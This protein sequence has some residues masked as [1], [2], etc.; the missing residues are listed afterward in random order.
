MGFDNLPTLDEALRAVGG[1][2]GKNITINALSISVQLM[3]LLALQ[4][5]PAPHIK[6]GVA[7]NW[8]DGVEVLRGIAAVSIML[9]HCISL[10]PWNVS[11]MPM[12]VFGA[13]WIDVDLFF[14]ISGYVIT[15]SAA[16][17][18]GLPDYARYFWRTR[19]ARILPLYYFTSV[20]FVAMVSSA[21]L[22]KD[23][24][25]QIVSHLFLV[26]YFFQNTAVNIN[27]VTWSLGV[28]MQFYL[29]AFFVVPLAARADRK[30]L[31]GNYLL[32]L[33]GVL[34]YRMSVW[35]WLRSADAP[36]ATISHVLSQVPA[37]IESFALGGLICLL[38]TAKV[39]HV[40]SVLLA[41]LAF[42]LFIAIYVIYDAN[43]A[44]YWTSQPMAVLFRSLIAAFAAIAL[45]AAFSSRAQ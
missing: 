31:V 38:G 25:F 15:G 35:H 13:G 17:Q 44:R 2:I 36:D 29:L 42:A 16:R 34:A 24:T 9:F 22:D 5:E 39:N 28:E 33:F 20:V 26:H 45:L 27:G 18:K 10:L 6:F 3:N 32:L 11:G 8:R 41:L 7:T 4:K 40:R 23:A 30:T 21:A 37:L 12:A 1:L 14:V 19:L 43:A